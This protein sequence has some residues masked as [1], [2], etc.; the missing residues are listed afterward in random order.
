MALE[1]TDEHKKLFAEMYLRNKKDFLM[2]THKIA[3]TFDNSPNP[4]EVISMSEELLNDPVVLTEIKRIEETPIK[5]SAVVVEIYAN[6]IKMFEMGNHTEYNK[7]M[8]LIAELEG[9]IKKDQ[10]DDGT[11][12][13]GKLKELAESVRIKTDG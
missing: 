6:A 7:A 4:H 11:F 10:K 5:K 1:F 2:H 13:M 8:R 12:G 3:K 9:F